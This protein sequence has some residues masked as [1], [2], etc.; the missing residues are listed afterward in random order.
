MEE[1]ITDEFPEKHLMILKAE[2]NNDEPWGHHSAS[3]TG[4][5]VYESGFY[6][7][8]IFKDAKDYVMRLSEGN[9]ISKKEIKYYYLTLDLRCS[10]KDIS[11]KVNGQ[12]LK[13][14]H[15]GYNNEAELMDKKISTL[16]ERQAGMRTTRRKLIHNKP[17]STKQTSQEARELVIDRGT[18]G[19]PAVLTIEKNL[20]AMNVGIKGITGVIAWKFKNKTMEPSWVVLVNEEWSMP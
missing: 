15:D 4:R 17:S 2:F 13:K 1:E 18:I 3:I 11:F 14:Y 9:K 16:A 8:S 10:R 19:S 6:W 7:P 12:R 20:I 5:K